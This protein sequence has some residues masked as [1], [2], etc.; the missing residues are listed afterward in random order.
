M[1]RPFA[2][3]IHPGHVLR[4]GFLEPLGLSA[5]AVAEAVDVPEGRLT[6]L[7]EWRKNPSRLG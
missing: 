2:G 5:Y 6:G 3:P 4:T 7:V 1:A